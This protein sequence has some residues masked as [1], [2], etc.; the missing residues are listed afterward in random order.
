M[1]SAEDQDPVE[2]V[3]ANQALAL[4][5]GH[6]KGMTATC[7]IPAVQAAFRGSELWP[8]GGHAATRCATHWGGPRRPPGVPM[9][10]RQGERAR[11]ETP[12]ERSAS[13]TVFRLQIARGAQTLS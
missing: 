4:F 5:D 10:G 6:Q 7:G 13:S 11:G 3:G 8:K 12:K 9:R 1:P 2:A